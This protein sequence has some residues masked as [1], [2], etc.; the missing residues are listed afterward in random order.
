MR[1]IPLSTCNRLRYI[2]RGIGYA[3]VLHFA[4]AGAKVYLA[5]RNE[6]AALG[7]IEKLNVQDLSPGN[8][9]VISLK[10]DLS[11]PRKARKSAEEFLKLESRLDILSKGT[12]LSA[13][14][15]EADQ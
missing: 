3:T 2:S 9:E 1:G 11:D 4:R 13:Q 5:A 8:G 7:A 6:M 10:L 12:Y 15:D 14:L